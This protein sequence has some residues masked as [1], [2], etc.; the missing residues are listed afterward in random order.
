MTVIQLLANDTAPPKGF[1][2][3]YFKVRKPDGTEQTLCRGS[4]V[5]DKERVEVLNALPDILNWE[6]TAEYIPDDHG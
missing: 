4:F 5:F 3:W 6:V 1:N 2:P